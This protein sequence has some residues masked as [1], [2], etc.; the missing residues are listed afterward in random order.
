MLSIIYV[1]HLM[2]LN[3]SVAVLPSSHTELIP[4]AFL[5]FLEFVQSLCIFCTWNAIPRYWHGSL[6]HLFQ[7]LSLPL[8]LNCNTLYYYSLSRFF[9]LSITTISF[10]YL[11]FFMVYFPHSNVSFSKT[12][13]CVCFV[14]TGKL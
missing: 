4:L 10:T 7:E 1:S 14:F 6:P 11:Y 8:Y 13:I 2:F 9:L 12:G 5:A 3:S